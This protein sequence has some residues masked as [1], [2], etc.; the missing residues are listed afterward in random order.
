MHNFIM[1]KNFF[2]EC[3][4]ATKTISCPKCKKEIEV[5]V[6]DN[7]IFCEECGETFETEQLNPFSEDFVWLPSE[8]F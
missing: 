3:L 8:K 4:K 7:E 2:D 6:E 5:N 1:Q